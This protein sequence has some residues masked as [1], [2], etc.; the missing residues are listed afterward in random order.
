MIEKLSLAMN[1]EILENI[2]VKVQN[3][4]ETFLLKN[5]KKKSVVWLMVLSKIFCSLG[6]MMD[7]FWSKKSPARNKLSLHVSLIFLRLIISSWLIMGNFWFLVQTI[8]FQRFLKLFSKMEKS[9][10]I[11]W[12]RS[13]VILGLFLSLKC[14]K[15]DSFF[16]VLIRN[17][18]EWLE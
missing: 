7:E 5:N 18:S 8:K 3:W 15:M 12:F 9:L 4:S 13:K 2:K 11:F 1:L 6:W 17:P 14:L 16:S 10:W